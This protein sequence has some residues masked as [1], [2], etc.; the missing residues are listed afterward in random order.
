MFEQDYII[1]CIKELVRA[2]LKLLFN[3]DTESPTVELLQSTEARETFEELLEM[4]DSGDINGAE[5]RLYDLIDTEEK[6]S[7]QIA[8]LFY[9]YLN[10]RSD[11]FLENHDFCREEIKQ[12]LEAVANRF[13]VNSITEMFLKDL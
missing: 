12:G 10:E 3:I 4:V 2:I 8:L 9:S 6:T 5:N 11:E 1:R 13:G 7:L